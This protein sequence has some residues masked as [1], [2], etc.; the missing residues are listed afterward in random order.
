M[1]SRTMTNVD[2]SCINCDLYDDDWN[3]LNSVNSYYSSSILRNEKK[4]R[5]AER[6]SIPLTRSTSEVP[7]SSESPEFFIK[8]AIK[9]IHKEEGTMEGKAK[10]EV[11]S[12]E[13]EVKRIIEQLTTENLLEMSPEEC[14]TIHNLALDSI[15]VLIIKEWKSIPHYI[16]R[17]I[18][19][20]I[21]NYKDLEI[22]Y[23]DD[24]IIM[25][26]D[27]FKEYLVHVLRK[28]WTRGDRKYNLFYTHWANHFIDI[29][30][31]WTC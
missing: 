28:L 3:P 7:E 2:L 27:F 1:Q 15:M 24:D 10:K 30:D 6:D 18:K 26:T 16:Q 11:H 22:M 8:D 12:V 9:L 13:R 4:P 25:F 19:G 20:V 21:A 5:R 17:T 29:Y 31:S 23:G 14:I